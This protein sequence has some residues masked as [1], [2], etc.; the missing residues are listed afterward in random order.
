MDA[1]TVIDR[2]PALTDEQTG[3]PN[4]R[5][6]DTVF[7]TLF[8]MARRG[9]PLTTLLVEVEG[10]A[11]VDGGREVADSG[12]IFRSLAKSIEPTIRQTDLLARLDAD[13]LVVGLVDCNLAGAAVVAQRIDGYLDLIREERG[14][15][16]SLGGAEFDKAFRE[17][18][19]LLGAARGALEI[20]RGRTSN[21]VEFFSGTRR[22]GE[23]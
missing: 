9:M 10:L 22:N 18:D 4:R 15:E 7:K 2:H 12:R 19:D 16:F 21:R 3:L 23:G 5:H 13:C 6:F 17:P 14:L 20:A 8:A 11:E 1:S